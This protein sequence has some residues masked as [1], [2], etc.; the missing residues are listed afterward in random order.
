MLLCHSN[1]MQLLGHFSLCPS[2]CQVDPTFGDRSI[3]LSVFALSQI[4]LRLGFYYLIEPRE[5]IGWETFQLETFQFVQR[6]GHLLGSFLFALIS[7]QQLRLVKV[8]LVI[9]S[10]QQLERDQSA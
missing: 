1:S 9:W 10:I 6:V 4:V 2:G 3:R 5:C 7:F 8:L